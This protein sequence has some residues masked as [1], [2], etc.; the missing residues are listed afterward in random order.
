MLERPGE[1]GC[2]PVHIGPE[3]SGDVML[4]CGQSTASPAGGVQ[5][6]T[7]PTIDGDAGVMSIDMGR[8]PPR[9]IDM[10]RAPEASSG[11]GADSSG[12]PPVGSASGIVTVTPCRELEEP[13][14]SGGDGEWFAAALGSLPILCWSF[15]KRRCLSWLTS[16]SPCVCIA[17]PCAWQM[18]PFFGCPHMPHLYLE[19]PVLVVPF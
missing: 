18:C 4:F 2:A 7:P 1:G 12:T 9:S 17:P 3:T 5:S 8:P 19:R 6:G 15:A 13:L 10:G 11:S 14:E 16:S